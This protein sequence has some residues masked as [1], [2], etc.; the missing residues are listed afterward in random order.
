MRNKS[1]FKTFIPQKPHSIPRKP[2]SIPRKPHS[3]P[4]KPWPRLSWNRK[5]GFRG[6]ECG[7]RG[8]KEGPNPIHTILRVRRVLKGL[9]VFNIKSI[10]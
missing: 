4:R 1:Q 8:M 2:H 7:F 6:T 5:C 10:C 9:K 3:V